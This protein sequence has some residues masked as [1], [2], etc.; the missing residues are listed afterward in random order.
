M[1]RLRTTTAYAFLP[2]MW[3]HLSLY[4][5]SAFAVGF[6]AGSWMPPQCRLAIVWPL[7]K[8]YHFS[9]PQVYGL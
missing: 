3:D 6:T 9:T 1:N 5:N 7:S 4:L 2:A 8:Y